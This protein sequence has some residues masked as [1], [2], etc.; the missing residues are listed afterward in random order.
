MTSHFKPL[1]SFYMV[2]FGWCMLQ[3]E[4]LLYKLMKCVFLALFYAKTALR[5]CQPAPKPEHALICEGS[6]TPAGS[7][8]NT[9]QIVHLL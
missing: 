1:P 2:L 3:R 7:N 9:Y 5:H 4:R 6:A 8:L